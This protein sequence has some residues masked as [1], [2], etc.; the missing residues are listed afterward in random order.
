MNVRK[1]KNSEVIKVLFSIRMLVFWEISH[2]SKHYWFEKLKNF[3][4]QFDFSF[5]KSKNKNKKY[6]ECLNWNGKSVIISKGFVISFVLWN[7]IVVRHQS[8]FKNKKRALLLTLRY[9]SYN[10]RV[11]RGSLQCVH[12]NK[13]Y[14]FFSQYHRYVVFLVA[15]KETKIL[16]PPLSLIDIS[17]QLS[18]SFLLPLFHSHYTLLRTVRATFF[19]QGKS[20]QLPPIILLERSSPSVDF[21]SCVFYQTS[22]S[23]LL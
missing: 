8:Q 20:N 16:L 21:I 14:F 12:S 1:F 22:K 11:Y 7:L 10:Y 19:Y 9:C 3:T 2:N 15:E 17:K 13:S 18:L 23:P 4:M 5:W 6:S